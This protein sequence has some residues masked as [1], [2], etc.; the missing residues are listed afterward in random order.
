MKIIPFDPKLSAY[1]SFNVNLGDFVCDFRFLWNGR[2][3][4][5]FVDLT[6]DLGANNSIRLVESSPLLAKH[7]HLGF[8]GDFRVLKFNKFAPD[9]ITYDNLGSDWKLVFGTKSE[10]EALDGV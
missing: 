6:T 1:Q 3:E 5:W 7:S 4:A 8:D 2:C 9:R 10:W